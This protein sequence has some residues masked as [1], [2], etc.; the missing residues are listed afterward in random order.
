MGIRYN[1]LD[2]PTKGDGYNPYKIGTPSHRIMARYL[3]DLKAYPNC[4]DPKHPGCDE[5][6]PGDHSDDINDIDEDDCHGT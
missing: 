1:Y 5:C 2:N 4:D 6:Q 3:S